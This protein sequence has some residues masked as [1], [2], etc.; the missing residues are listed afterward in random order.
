MF[1]TDTYTPKPNTLFEPRPLRTISMAQIIPPTVTKELGTQEPYH[2]SYF[3][4]INPE[5]TVTPEDIT[6]LN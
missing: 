3:W 2:K 5:N 1:G 6:A 4:W